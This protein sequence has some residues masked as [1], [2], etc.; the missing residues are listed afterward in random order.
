MKMSFNHPYH[1]VSVSPWP[2]LSS[3]SIVMFFLS[4][5]NFLMNLQYDLLL[6]SFFLMMLLFYQWWRDVIRES[7][8]Q[9]EHTS[10]IVK[11]MK[12]GMILFIMSELL[13][14]ISFFWSYF[15]FYLAPSMDIGMMWPPEGIKMFNPMNIPMLNTV[16]LISSG[17]TLTYSHYNILKMNY[18]LSKKWLMLTIFL[19]IYFSLLQWYEYNESLFSIWDSV[20]GS[21]FYL[22][23]G[24]HGLHV[25]I[26]TIFLLICLIR[27]LK[28][29][30]SSIHHFGFEAAS[31]YWHFVDVVWLFLYLFIYWLPFN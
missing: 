12:F 3:L 27:L 25:I 5:I 30:F 9:G 2:L 31:W 20:Y 17:A 7:M 19:G 23:T 18:Y 15:H 13:F 6:V 24:F 21:N 28:L 14:F 11:M 29:E 16:I 4:T 26:G 8:Y 10:Y 22:L 1:M